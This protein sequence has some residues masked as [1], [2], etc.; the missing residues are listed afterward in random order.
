MKCIQVKKHL[1]SYTDNTS[2]D[3][4]RNS[5]ET[6]LNECQS[7]MSEYDSIKSILGLMHQLPVPEK[8][9]QQWQSM[10]QSILSQIAKNNDKFSIYKNKYLH[11]IPRTFSKWAVAALLVFSIVSIFTISLS[12]NSQSGFE[13]L[14]SL[15]RIVDVQGLAYSQNLSDSGL[16]KPIDLKSNHISGNIIK[17]SSQA[18]LKLQTDDKSF[19]DISENTSIH[20][21]ECSIKKQ[22]FTLKQGKVTANVGKRKSGQIYQI[23]TPN[24]TCEVIGTRFSL[25]YENQSDTLK[26][27]TILYVL[28]GKVL[29]RITNGRSVFVDSGETAVAT[30]DTI[31]PLTQNGYLKTSI[32]SSENYLKDRIKNTKG[33]SSISKQPCKYPKTDLYSSITSLIDSGDLDKAILELSKIYSNPNKSNEMRIYAMQKEAW[34][35]KMKKNYSKSIAL[36]QRIIKEAESSKQKE[37]ALFQIASIRHLEMNDFDGAIKD[38]QQYINDFPHGIWAEE[39][40]FTLAELLHLKKNHLK[41][42][43]I[44]KSIVINYPKS[45]KFENALYSLAR[46]YSRD[47]SDCDRAVEIYSRLETQFPNGSYTEDALFWKAECLFLQKRITQSLSAFQQYLQKY[48]NGKWVTEA[49]IRS[50]ISVTAGAAQ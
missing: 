26:S 21:N 48:P 8:N 14:F 11:F 42:A 7:C 19:L 47:L 30:S 35:W 31:F 17:T 16:S 41:A 27:K 12:L 10:Q 32:K 18:T 34:C 46:L 1:Y 25:S 24:A 13:N 5:I 29:F 22:L 23:Q 6:H 15:P 45:S 43:D 9:N 4:L 49:R 20:I 28:E 33:S 40:T 50:G 38:L 3:N 44:Y 36:F 39:V 37:S 2:D